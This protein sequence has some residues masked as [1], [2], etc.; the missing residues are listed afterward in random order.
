MQNNGV[1]SG[2]HSFVKLIK[3][4]IVLLF[5]KIMEMEVVGDCKVVLSRYK[6]IQT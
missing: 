5:K 4:Y 2:I 1:K 3:L 6:Y